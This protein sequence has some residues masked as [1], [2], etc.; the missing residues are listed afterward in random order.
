MIG[1][2]VQTGK[3]EIDRIA[4]VP[5][6]SRAIKHK[7]VHKMMSRIAYLTSDQWWALTQYAEKVIWTG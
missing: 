5:N 4:A 7:V 2:I 3:E 6:A 1:N